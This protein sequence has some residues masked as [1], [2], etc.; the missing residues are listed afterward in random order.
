M[1]FR[2]VACALTLA[3]AA[4]CGSSSSNGNSGGSGGAGGSSAGGAGAGGAGAPGDAGVP[5]VCV[6][7]PP[8]TSVSDVSGHF[9]Y[10]WAGSQIV[11]A[12][13]FTQPF[14]TTT[15]SI[16]LVD[17]TQ[18]GTKVTVHGQ[19]CDQF[20]DNGNSPVQVVIPDAFKKSLPAFT[21]NGTFAQASDGYRH[22]KLPG[23]VEVEGAH[24]TNP[25]TDPLPTSATDPRVYDEDG[26]GKPGMTIK[27]VKPIDGSIYVV[28]RQT[29]G[30]DGVAVSADRIE[31]KFTYN[32]EQIILESN[33]ASI[34][35]LS[36]QAHADPVACHSTFVIARVPDT[37]DCTWVLNHESTLFP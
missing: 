26:D 16:L 20:I 12:P 9:A 24:L 21:R 7:Q 37:A 30:F 14:T 17:Q 3:L 25:A 28:Q 31:G 8:A 2:L 29:T 33:P 1:T 34:K 27:L 11:Q 32:S 13:A 15:V 36:P 18:N 4:G 23:F 19:Y 10:R 6:S 22:F 5:D 35:Q